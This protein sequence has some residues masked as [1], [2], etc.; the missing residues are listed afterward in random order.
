MPSPSCEEVVREEPPDGIAI[1][2]TDLISVPLVALD[3]PI[4]SLAESANML[5]FVIADLA[6]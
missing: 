4:R 1:L 2:I 3:M 5:V 6:S